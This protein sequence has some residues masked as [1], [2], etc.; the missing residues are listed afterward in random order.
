MNNEIVLQEKVMEKVG[1]NAAIVYTY[2]NL[3]MFSN[4]AHNIKEPITV[5]SLSETI[6]YLSVGQVRRALKRL[7]DAGMV[8]P[9]MPDDINK[10]SIGYKLK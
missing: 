7:I 9:Y 4:D 5:Y 8:S 10:K 6:K 1:V 3:I 2:I